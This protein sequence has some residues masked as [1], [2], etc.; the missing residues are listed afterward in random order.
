MYPR[1]AMHGGIPPEFRRYP[2]D[3]GLLE[4]LLKNPAV[5]GMVSG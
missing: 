2:D 1:P 3:S 5:S 4:S